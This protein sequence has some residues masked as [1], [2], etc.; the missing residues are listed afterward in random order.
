MKEFWEV[1]ERV[2]KMALFRF[3]AHL[4]NNTNGV[5]KSDSR[6]PFIMGCIFEASDL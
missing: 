4:R 3:A 6:F 1:L 2:I 5:L